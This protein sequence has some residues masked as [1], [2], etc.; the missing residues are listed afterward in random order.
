MFPIEAP[1]GVE[2]GR[3]RKRRHIAALAHKGLTKMF[4]RSIFALGLVVAASGSASAVI[5]PNGVSLNGFSTN[6]LHLNALTSNALTENALTANGL[7]VNA[8]TANALTS[9][10]LVENS[11]V[12]NALT[13]NALVDNGVKF[14]GVAT[15]P[16]SND[17][18]RVIAIELPAPAQ[19]DK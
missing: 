14:N 10:A 6:G 13:Q 17:G 2:I 9:N 4:K 15:S 12:Q 8:L 11:L 16:L 5:S 18:L 1:P 7:H 19:T 3:H